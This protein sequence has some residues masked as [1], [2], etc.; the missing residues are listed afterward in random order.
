MI[1]PKLTPFGSA[2]RR[3]GYRFPEGNDINFAKQPQLDLGSPA[4][5][6]LFPKAVWP[7]EL[8]GTIPISVA[9]EGE[10]K[11]QPR[12]GEHSNF[13]ALAGE[14]EITSSGTMGEA[15]SWF[16]AVEFE[17]KNLTGEAEVK[18]PRFFGIFKPFDKP[19]FMARIGRFDPTILSWGNNRI[20]NS[21]I[22]MLTQNPRRFTGTDRASAT[23]LENNPAHLGIELTG[24]VGGG[25]FL[26]AAGVVE[27]NSDNAATVRNDAKDVYGSLHYKFGGMRIDGVVE[28][29]GGVTSSTETSFPWRE[30]S[31][32]I[33]GF[34]YNGKSKIEAA[35]EDANSGFYKFGVDANIIYKDFNLMAAGSFEKH[36]NAFADTIAADN[37]FLENLPG[38]RA[39][40]DLNV[41]Q[42]FAQVDY[43]VFPWLVP[44]VKYD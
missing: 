32:T 36:R 25:R 6:R 37:I 3:A 44:S 4:W 30:K 39:R 41:T 9:F 34:W 23:T 2:F 24:I 43:V 17:S 13:S 8:P 18:V 35:N 14:V 33:G 20:L 12:K 16:G 7:G 1:F 42:W 11:Y 28:E 15:I 29:A 22:W 27:G 31:L 10:Y 21:R 19:L 26:Y 5:K 40:K 38:V